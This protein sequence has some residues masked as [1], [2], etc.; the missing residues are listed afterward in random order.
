MLAYA[1][2]AEG[3]GFLDDLVIIGYE[4]AIG[5]ALKLRSYIVATA[6]HRDISTLR[7]RYQRRSSR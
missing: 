7:S 4:A 2:G 5:D 1:D 3:S 6:M